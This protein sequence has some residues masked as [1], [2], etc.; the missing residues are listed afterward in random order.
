VASKSR[1]WVAL[2]SGLSFLAKSLTA[3]S[4][5]IVVKVAGNWYLMKGDQPE[6]YPLQKYKSLL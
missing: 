5:E 1:P 3:K 2:D 6:F 4:W